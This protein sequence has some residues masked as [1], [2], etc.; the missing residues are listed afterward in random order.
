MSTD[1]LELA[2]RGRMTGVPHTPG[3][4]EYLTRESGQIAL[5][6]GGERW[7]LDPGDVVAFRGDQRHSFLN[8]G[9][10]PAIGHSVVVLGRV[11]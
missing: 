3:T 6:V 9:D 7:T 4:R 1:R 2:P 8:P 10:R 11:S 5:V